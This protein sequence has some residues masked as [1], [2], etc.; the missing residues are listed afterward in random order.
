M[1]ITVF[2][3]TDMVTVM[4]ENVNCFSIKHDC[5]MLQVANIVIIVIKTEALD[6][7]FAGEYCRFVVE[8]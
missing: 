4:I 8:S 5:C 3:F 2:V 7:L 1:F 6:I